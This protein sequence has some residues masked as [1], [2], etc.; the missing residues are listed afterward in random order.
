MWYMVTH[1]TPFA[2]NYSFTRNWSTTTVL[3]EMSMVDTSCIFRYLGQIHINWYATR[4]YRQVSNDIKFHF[5]K[6]IVFGHVL[7]WNMNFRVLFCFNELCM[8][9][10]SVQRDTNF[11]LHAVLLNNNPFKVLTPITVLMMSEMLFLR[12]PS[13]SRITWWVLGR[14]M[15]PVTVKMIFS[16]CSTPDFKAKY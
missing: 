11:P 13:M 2:E 14:T 8:Q 9:V 7:H 12:V 4:Y 15:W 1:S 3:I 10:N 5:I 16:T 6:K